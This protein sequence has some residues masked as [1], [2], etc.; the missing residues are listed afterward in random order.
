MPCFQLLPVLTWYWPYY[1]VKCGQFNCYH[2]GGGKSSV[3]QE[4][5]DLR[6]WCGVGRD[7]VPFLR[8]KRHSNCAISKVGSSSWSPEK[9]ASLFLCSKWAGKSTKQIL[10]KNSYS[11]LER[12]LLQRHRLERWNM[13]V[14]KYFYP[15]LPIFDFVSPKLLTACEHSC[16]L[17]DL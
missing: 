9:Y 13:G 3:Q 11:Q 16:H 5:V 1:N 2:E 12:Q 4:L 10:Q 17:N 14:R 8:T 15:V 7:Q 6:W